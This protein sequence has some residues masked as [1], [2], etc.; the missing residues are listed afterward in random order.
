[1]TSSSP[2]ARAPRLALAVAAAALSLTSLTPLSAHAFMC[3][4]G[5]GAGQVQVGVASGPGFAGAPI[6][7]VDPNYHGDTSKAYEDAARDREEAARASSDTRADFIAW[8]NTSIAQIE[9]GR[10]ALAK[11]D[12]NTS[13]AHLSPEYY[14]G[15]WTL[16]DLARRKAKP[17]ENCMALFRSDRG[18][19]GLVGPGGDYKG[20]MLMFWSKDVPTP[21]GTQLVPVSLAQDD[22]PNT[23]T[24]RAYNYTEPQGIGAVAFG[25]PSIE[26]LLSNMQEKQRFRVV[27]NSQ[28]VVDMG[29]SDGHAARDALKNCVTQAR[30]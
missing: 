20:A 19:L 22:E 24:V 29:W 5:P 9:E 13:I 10:R 27:M 3:P 4:G 6:C 21:K 1:M 28:L 18:L 26:A 16:P 23:Q 30:R 11:I 12:R 15:T 8:L 25:V 14:R 7:G 17:G 2:W